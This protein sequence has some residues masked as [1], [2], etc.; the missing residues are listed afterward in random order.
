MSPG[1]TD[2]VCLKKPSEANDPDDQAE[3]LRAALSEADPYMTGVIESVYPRAWQAQ[4]NSRNG[5]WR[6]DARDPSNYPT[7][8][9]TEITVSYQDSVGDVDGND[10]ETEPPGMHQCKYP[11]L[12][13]STITQH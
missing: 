8:Q 12:A 13:F 2:G 1:V 7:Q 4:I 5:P 6:G 11:S 10:D 9:P 3:E